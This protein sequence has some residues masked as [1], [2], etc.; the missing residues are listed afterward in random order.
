MIEIT[1]L[2]NDKVKYWSKLNK[3][4]YREEEGLYLVEGEHLVK[5]A[6]NFGIV[7]CVMTVSEDEYD[8]PTYHVTTEIMNKISEL[9]SAPR[10]MA[11]VKKN[12]IKDIEG[13]VLILDR[14]QDPGN[15]G[16]IIRSAVAFGVKNIFLGE[17]CV[18]AY[19]SKVVRSSEG[20]LFKINLLSGDV[21]DLIEKLKNDNYRILGT[22]V[23]GGL[24]VKK[25][26]LLDKWALIIGNEG[27]GVSE[28][29][30]NS[31]DDYL[32]I[33]MS[34]NCESLNAAIAASIIMYEL[35]R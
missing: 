13:N 7:E 25:I 18:D 26:N 35:N 21:L 29:V 34:A 9:E 17:G 22:R 14:I 4:K 28:E 24:E 5:E 16:T 31:C 2:T 12:K 33:K 23:T 11:V 19:N 20:M 1:S 27:Q 6:L 30:L 10:I 15:L 3:R 8:V 32:Y